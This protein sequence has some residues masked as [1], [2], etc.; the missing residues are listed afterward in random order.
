MASNPHLRQD[1]ERL[2][3]QASALTHG[4]VRLPLLATGLPVASQL[5]TLSR[6]KAALLRTVVAL[7]PNVRTT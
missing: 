5:A 7:D 4:P 2:R 1:P 6:G 3:V